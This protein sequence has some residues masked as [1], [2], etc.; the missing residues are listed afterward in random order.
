M[1]SEEIHNLELDIKRLKR[2]VSDLK[3]FNSNC[4]SGFRPK[5][6]WWSGIKKLFVSTDVTV[7]IRPYEVC[8]ELRI[9]P[10]M[11]ETKTLSIELAK[12]RDRYLKY[13]L[14]E[15]Q[16]VLLV[17]ENLYKNTILVKN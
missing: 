11:V 1:T 6:Y 17:A 15:M 2:A 16:D 14:S 5:G 12:S 13:L 3:H 8:A 9:H 10:G 7:L 4:N